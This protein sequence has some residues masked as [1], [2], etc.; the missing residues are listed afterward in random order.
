MK[1]EKQRI[2]L[3]IWEAMEKRGI[4]RFPR[5][6]KGRIPNFAG[7]ETAAGLL[8]N[9]RVWK[10][11]SVLKINPD[12]PQR[13]VRQRALEEGKLLIMPTPRLKSGFII[14]DPSLIPQR[15]Y[16]DASTIRGAFRLG[17]I[18][19]ADDL[20][21]TVSHVDLIVEGS[22]A[23][24]REGGRLGKGEGYGDKEY[25][26][27]HNIGL[28]DRC[29]PIAT[30]V[31]DIQVWKEPLPQEPHDAKVWLIATPSRLI[32]TRYGEEKSS[33]CGIGLV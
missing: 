17:K 22:V 23:V 9:T 12:S 33:E 6:V 8:V 27:L 5:P 15:Y 7:A 3:V 13:P 30:T 20:P 4:A 2:R 18:V 25:A 31:H 14:L 28:V 29:T 11:S 16:K 1:E 21:N 24:D 32:V 10:S 19:P 26:S